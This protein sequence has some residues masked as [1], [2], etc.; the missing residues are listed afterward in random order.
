MRMS[1]RNANEMKMSN[2]YP[3]SILSS[4]IHL[5]RTEIWAKK[6]YSGQ[7]WGHF[8]STGPA[9]AATSLSS[10]GTDIPESKKSLLNGGTSKPVSGCRTITLVKGKTAAASSAAASTE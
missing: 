2:G 10:T 4:T 8:R 1:N 6:H 3:G 5:A 9:P 7:C